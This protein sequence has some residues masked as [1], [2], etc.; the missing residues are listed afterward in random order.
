MISENKFINCEGQIASFVEKVDHFELIDNFF[1]NCDAR[2]VSF[3]SNQFIEVPIIIKGNLF[4]NL[5]FKNTYYAFVFG[6][7]YIL[8][9][10][11]F[12]NNIFKNIGG[13][14]VDLDKENL[15][16]SFL[17]CSFIDWERE[18]RNN[19]IFIFN[20]RNS[21]TIF[22]DCF[23][24]RN[25]EIVSEILSFKTNNC[26]IFEN[27]SFVNN[28]V[29]GIIKIVPN[30]Q[31]AKFNQCTLLNCTFSNNNCQLSSGLF[32]INLFFD[33]SIEN[34][35]F[36]RNLANGTANLISIFKN[37]SQMHDQ[38]IIKIDKCLFLSNN[39]SHCLA[40]YNKTSKFEITNCN[41]INNIHPQTEYCILSCSSEF[42][43]ENSTIDS[44]E[45]NF[46]FESYTKILN[47]LSSNFLNTKGGFNISQ[48]IESANIENSIFSDCYISE[49]A[50]V[51]VIS[52]EK[53]F[54]NNNIVNFTSSEDGKS[55][56]GMHITSHGNIIITNNKFTRIRKSKSC[57]IYIK[58]YSSNKPENTVVFNYNTIEEV[59]D[60]P[61]GVFHIE[62]RNDFNFDCN[63]IK[64]CRISGFLCQ[65]YLSNNFFTLTNLTLSGC[66]SKC[67][68]GGGFGL[69]LVFGSNYIREGIFTMQDCL[70]ENN[71]SNSNSGGAFAIGGTS[72]GR[73]E[74]I[75]NNCSFIGNYAD[76]NGGALSIS[77]TLP[78][79]IHNCTFIDNLS[80]LSG[81]AIFID[82]FKL[83]TGILGILPKVTISKS[84]FISNKESNMNYHDCGHAISFKYEDYAE[85]VLIIT[86][87]CQFI[88]NCNYDHYG[89]SIKVSPK[90]FLF[91]N[92]TILFTDKNLSIIGLN[93]GLVENITIRS[94]YFSNN[95]NSFDSISLNG[96]G[97]IVIICGV[98][99]LIT[100]CTFYNSSS[101][102]GA[103]YYC[104]NINT[105]EN[106]LLTLDNC[107]FDECYGCFQFDGPSFV[108]RTAIVRNCTFN[109]CSYFANN[110]WTT[111]YMHDQIISPVIEQ[112]IFHNCG[113]EKQEYVIEIRISSFI[114]SPNTFTMA[115]NLFIFDDFNESCGSIYLSLSEFYKAYIHNC[116]FYNSSRNEDHYYNP[117]C[118][119]VDYIYSL[120]ISDCHFFGGT[121]IKY[122]DYYNHYNKYDDDAFVISLRSYVMIDVLIINCTF[123]STPG[124]IYSYNKCIKVIG[125]EFKNTSKET[126]YI[127]GEY[128]IYDAEIIKNHFY[129]L[130][131]GIMIYYYQD[132]QNYT[133]PII[134]ENLFEKI[135]TPLI[136]SFTYDPLH[137][138][139]FVCY[140]DDPITFENN[141]FREYDTQHGGFGAFIHQIE[142]QIK[143]IFINCYF[144]DNSQPGN[145]GAAFRGDHN[146]NGGNCSVTF[147]SCY[148]NRNNGRSYGGCLHILHELLDVIIKNCIFIDNAVDNYS[149]DSGIGGVIYVK[150]VHELTINDCIFEG[151]HAPE[152]QVVYC[153]D[154]I[155]PLSITN[156]KFIDNVND[157]TFN[158]YLVNPQYS[159]ILLT[160]KINIKDCEFLCTRE[161]FSYPFLFKSMDD[162]SDVSF[163]NITCNYTS[164]LY[165]PDQISNYHFLL[166]VL[167]KTLLLK[168]IINILSSEI[169]C[170]NFLKMTIRNQVE[171]KLIFFHVFILLITHSL[172]QNLP[173]EQYIL[174][175]YIIRHMKIMLLLKIAHL[176]DALA[177][178]FAF[179]VFITIMQIIT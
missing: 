171:L 153:E 177:C 106:G 21:K 35:S 138:F 34:C 141:T 55:I 101:N 152:C 75:I 164:L 14:L 38:Q 51:V 11:L 76:E 118:I 98:D 115:D 119:Y 144:L 26:P 33:L 134:R 86:D 28:S 36:L 68:T 88:D 139:H 96:Y 20:Y 31:D 62:K 56:G 71:T 52:N 175:T 123:D 13:T 114:E 7:I 137:A 169:H 89:A 170:F 84:I 178:V 90:V 161:I 159:F 58:D 46:E 121:I 151:N 92:S 23:F 4:E 107:F 172:M 29:P 79:L 53:C 66:E 42:L 109:N 87:E 73:T 174:I 50:A 65:I 69:W 63:I 91:E 117:N 8:N 16:L 40:N 124:A 74:L 136:Y 60:V 43:F 1:F 22:K 122:D 80:K 95:G 173:M 47:I 61:S 32:V 158:Y 44:Q 99:I 110:R 2:Y 19:G 82:P 126:I 81:G 17:N 3:Q 5:E 166:I 103:I 12:E 129:E 108:N 30:N 112:C 147:D 85:T 111:I 116:T 48:M 37:T 127:E 146:Y 59:G 163:V 145:G 113:H 125:N 18:S 149:Y 155:L 64:N 165:V 94:S 41:F 132:S 70:F 167:P 162:V 77:S 130:H 128:G 120:E 24:E 27:C 100:N 39:C 142:H 45:K 78:A 67:N 179:I 72:T 9:D 25:K 156:C 104:E 6:S 133:N 105:Y 154:T 176:K 57:G 143:L 10:I 102:S 15:T 54:F 83:G 160:N 168:V 150:A 135:T 157:Q 148:F 49:Q 131:R 93:I 97:D 140:S